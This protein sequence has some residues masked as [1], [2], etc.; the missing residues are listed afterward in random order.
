MTPL[1]DISL[2]EDPKRDADQDDIPLVMEKN[3][4]TDLNLKPVAIE[5]HTHCFWVVRERRVDVLEDERCMKDSRS[6]LLIFFLGCAIDT[7]D[8]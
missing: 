2:E 1:V 5:C 7:I 4:D 3:A 6:P 8:A